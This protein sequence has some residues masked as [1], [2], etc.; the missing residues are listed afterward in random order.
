[1]A[2]IMGLRML[3]DFMEGDKYYKINYPNHNLDRCKNQFKLC[4]DIL[5]QLNDLK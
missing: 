3:T 2:F 5:D 1:M 4:Q